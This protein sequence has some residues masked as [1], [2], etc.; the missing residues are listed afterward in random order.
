MF[1]CR[2]NNID[3]VIDKKIRLLSYYVSQVSGTDYVNCTVGL[4]MYHS[5]SFGAGECKY[6]ERFFDI[7]GDDYVQVIRKIRSVRG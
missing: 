1:S 2:S 6:A 4:N 3:S 5:K 7:P